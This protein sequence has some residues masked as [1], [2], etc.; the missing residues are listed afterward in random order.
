M[1]KPPAGPLCQG[2]AERYGSPGSIHRNDRFLRGGDHRLLCVKGFCG[3]CGSRRDLVLL[4]TSTRCAHSIITSLWS[5]SNTWIL[6]TFRENT[7]VL[8]CLCQLTVKAA[9][10]Q[11]VERNLPAGRIWTNLESWKQPAKE[12]VAVCCAET[13]SRYG[14]RNFSRPHCSWTYR[15]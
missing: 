14:K 4:F 5:G 11:E 6:I 13:T 12:H 2:T 7:G 3:L 9:Q 10:P 1:H 8:A 15:I